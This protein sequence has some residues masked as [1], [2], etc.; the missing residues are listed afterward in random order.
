MPSLLVVVFI[1]QLLIHLINTIGA[2][3]INEFVSLLSSKL[4]LLLLFV[5]HSAPSRLICDFFCATAMD[6]L[7]LPSHKQHLKKC[8][9]ADRTAAGGCEAEAGDECHQLA[10]RVCQVGEAEADA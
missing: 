2:L 1:L 10:G 5:L 9:Q 6:H 7:Q 3:V 4:P 8:P